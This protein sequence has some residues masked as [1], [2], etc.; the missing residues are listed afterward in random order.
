MRDAQPAAIF[1][2][3][4]RP[5][6]YLISRTELDFELHEDHTLVM[7]KLHIWRNPESP[8]GTELVLH[9]QDLELLSI[10]LDGESLSDEAYRLIE[11]R[12]F[13][14]W[15]SCWST[16]QRPSGNAGTAGLRSGDLPTPA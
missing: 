14:S 9:G 7:A 6:A 2:K 13:P 12:S 11:S 5:P 4:Y 1:L 16:A 10:G 3:D 15:G 8:E